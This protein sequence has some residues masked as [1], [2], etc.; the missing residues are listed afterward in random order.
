MKKRFL[1]ALVSILTIGSMAMADIQSSPGAKWTW[2]RK[3]SRGLANVIYG[4]MEIFSTWNRSIRSDG[5]STAGTETPIEGLRRSLV[6]VGYGVFEIITFPEPAY[7]GTFRPPY[8]RKARIDPWKGY[9]E[10]PPQLGIQTQSNYC[11]TQ[12]W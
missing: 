4:P 12:V 8:Y 10:F 9:D 3:L 11:R 5:S 1:L 6:R 7:K 2:S